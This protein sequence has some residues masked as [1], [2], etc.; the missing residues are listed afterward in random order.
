MR[1][2]AFSAKSI[3]GEGLA[4]IITGDSLGVWSSYFSII[5]LLTKA[6]NENKSVFTEVTRPGLGLF[7]LIE[8]RVGVVGVFKLFT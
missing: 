6:S 1:F 2:L 4:G 5:F 3:I 7:I 8:V